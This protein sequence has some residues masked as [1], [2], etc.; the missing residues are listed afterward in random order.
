MQK[1]ER[2]AQKERDRDSF[3]CCPTEAL[4]KK[5]TLKVLSLFN[6]TPSIP[7]DNPNSGR[8]TVCVL[9]IL[10]TPSETQV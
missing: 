3:H 8:Q 1:R 2:D 10:L 4:N 9:L 6:L 5:K 7:L